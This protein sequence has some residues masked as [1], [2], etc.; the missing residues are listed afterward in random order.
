MS[1]PAVSVIVPCRNERPHLAAFLREVLGQRDVAGGFEVLVAD[2]GSTDGS[3]EFLAA[4]AASDPRITLIDNP[5]GTV[6]PGLNAA[7]RA[8]RGAI[9]ARMDVHT[10]Y[11]DD[12]LATCVAVLAATGAANVGGPART[13][14]AGF[15]P[16]AIAAAYA[17]PFAV[18]GARFHDPDYAGE[19][20]TVPY[21]CWRRATLVASGGFD[22]ALVRNQDDE[23]NLRLRRAGGVIWQSPA[24]R[25]WYHPRGSLRALFRQYFQYGFWKV[26]VIRK[27]RLPASWRH[28][29]PGTAV[30]AGLAL[31]VAAPWSAPAALALAL[32]VAAWL[33]LAVPAGVLAARAAGDLRL[34]AVLPVVFAVYHAAYGLGFLRGLWAAGRG[35][36]AAPAAAVELTR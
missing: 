25:S 22:E 6:S 28:L 12:Y 9:I 2:G 32:A 19:V 1:A 17:S 14:A 7:I 27:H 4:A 20:D 15:L 30:A 16:R 31:S 18:G 26:H 29:V 21:G 34:A 35:P 13:A 3:R 33:A 8:A 11:A 36:A 24:I 10:R 5:A 23:L